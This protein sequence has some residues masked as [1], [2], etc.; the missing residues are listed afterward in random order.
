MRVHQVRVWWCSEFKM[1]CVSF[2]DIDDNPILES[3]YTHHKTDAVISAKH[4]FDKGNCSVV[5][6]E[7]RTGAVKRVICHP[8]WKHSR[9]WRKWNNHENMDG[10]YGWSE[11]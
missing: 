3:E 11:I 8:I 9:H 4:H 10:V 2:Y 7:M 1:W 6:I 5:V